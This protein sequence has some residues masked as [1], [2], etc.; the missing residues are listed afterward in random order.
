LNNEQLDIHHIALF[1]IFNRLY[2]NC[3]GSDWTNYN[4]LII[5]ELLSYSDYNFSAEEQHM[6]NIGY[7]EIDQHILEH[8]CFT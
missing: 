1:G 5:D 3:K 2:E 8:E 7:K 4:D 6:R